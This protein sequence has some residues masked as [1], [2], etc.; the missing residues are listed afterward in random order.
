MD[1]YQ[2]MGAMQNPQGYVMQ[3]AMA[4]MVQQ[5][6]D[7]WKAT[8]EKYGGM[9]RSDMLK[10]LRKEYKRQGQDLDAIAR[11]YGIPLN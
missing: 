2:A 11:Q 10:A 8:Q 4:K 7:A 1:M 9:N 5:N 6:P 3:Q